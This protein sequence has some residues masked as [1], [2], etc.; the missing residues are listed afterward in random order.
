MFGVIFILALGVQQF[1][2]RLL[3]GGGWIVSLMP[4]LVSAA[5]TAG[6][7][8][9][10]MVMI[11]N[12]QR[13][14]ILRY[15]DGPE[16]L[17]RLTPKHLEHLV[18]E[19]FKRDGAQRVKHRG[20]WEDDTPEG[21]GG[22]DVEAWTKDGQHVLVQC[23]R[24]IGDAIA[25]HEIRALLGCVTREKADRGMFVTTSYFSDAAEKEAFDQPI[26]LIQFHQLWEWV[27]RTNTDEMVQELA[28]PKQVPG[29][30]EVSHKATLVCADCGE[31]MGLQESQHGPFLGCSGYWQPHKCQTKVN[32][33]DNRRN[34][35]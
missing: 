26:D 9:A 22:V 30:L 5:L 17:H 4:S 31:E 18:C 24:W 19:L 3:P 2:S 34:K 14:A 33:R 23:K 20:L 7:C 1:V 10:L 32:V 13:R 16:A 27:Q 28:K 12:V 8:V 21:D 29:R 6:I 15:M 11:I 35:C 25:P